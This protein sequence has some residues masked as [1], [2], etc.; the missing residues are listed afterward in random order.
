MPSHQTILEAGDPSDIS[1][2]P[3]KLSNAKHHIA[4]FEIALMGYMMFSIG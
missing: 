1:S 2:W 4:L 3:V